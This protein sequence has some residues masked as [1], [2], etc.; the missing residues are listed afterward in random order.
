MSYCAHLS[1]WLRVFNVNLQQGSATSRSSAHPPKVLKGPKGQTCHLT[2][3][4]Q[5]I[6]AR[7]ES[8]VVQFCYTPVR[9]YNQLLMTESTIIA[10]DSMS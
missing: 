8:C 7:F 1:L 10:P 9:G 6:Y 3:Q 4:A 2:N 5:H